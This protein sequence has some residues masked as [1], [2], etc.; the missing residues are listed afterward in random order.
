M[1]NQIITNLTFLIKQQIDIC[2]NSFIGLSIAINLGTERT[3]Q[4]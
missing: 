2:S 3:I 4:N 1:D